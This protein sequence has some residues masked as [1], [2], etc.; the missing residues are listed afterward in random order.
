MSKKKGKTREEVDTRQVPNG[1]LITV[2]RGEKVV[3]KTGVYGSEPP[4]RTLAEEISYLDWCLSGDWSPSFDRAYKAKAIEAARTSKNHQQREWLIEHSALREC[5]GDHRLFEQDADVWILLARAKI[6]LD[7]GNQDEA[8]W[9][10][11]EARKLR[12]AMHAPMPET[13]MVLEA[14]RKGGKTVADRH[15]SVMEYCAQLILGSEV[16]KADLRTQGDLA[17]KLGN[18][19]AIYIKAHQGELKGSQLANHADKEAESMIRRWLFRTQNNVIREAYEERL[20]QEGL[21]QR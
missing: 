8:R 21:P 7:E 16:T 19:A 18:L 9:L 4:H 6:A 5:F 17:K 14:R 1:I 2:R 13:K 11:H 20:R 10:F 15:Q 3:S 12:K